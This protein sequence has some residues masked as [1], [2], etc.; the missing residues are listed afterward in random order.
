MSQ[1]HVKLHL[2]DKQT[3]GH[4]RHVSSL[5]S[6]VAAHV[7]ERFLVFL[8]SDEDDENVI[9]ASVTIIFSSCVLLCNNGLKR[10]RGHSVRVV[11]PI[12][13]NGFVSDMYVASVYPLEFNTYCADISIRTLYIVRILMWA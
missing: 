6:F 10:R 5:C 9:L 1:Q 3:N 4:N 12:S 7:K 8:M 13:T 11:L 2:T